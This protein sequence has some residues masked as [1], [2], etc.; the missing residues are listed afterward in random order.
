MYKRRCVKASVLLEDI[1]AHKPNTLCE[2]CTLGPH[3][4]SESRP[5]L[6]HSPCNHAP[7]H[8]STSTL[9]H[10]LA[11]YQ[12]VDPSLFIHL[13]NGNVVAFWVHEREA[14]GAG[15]VL[16]REDLGNG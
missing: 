3:L 11:C 13:Y 10:A 6:T 2:T 14:T 12:E 8:H 9:L 5:C 1:L 7:P 15:W 16:V 4:I